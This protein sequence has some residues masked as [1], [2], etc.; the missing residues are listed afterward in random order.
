MVTMDRLA[1]TEYV[2]LADPAHVTATAFGFFYNH[3]EHRSRTDA[4]QLYDGRCSAAKVTQLL[5]LL[6]ELYAPTGLDYQKVSGHDQATYTALLPELSERG[7]SCYRCWMMT[8][9]QPPQR[10]ANPA[11][12]VQVVEPATLPLLDALY[13]T[14]DGLDQGYLFE[15]SQAARVGGERLLALKDGQAIGCTGWFV[16]NGVA[17]FRHV[18]T[19]APARK[20][21][22][23]TTLIRYI[24]EHPT[25][26]AQDALVIF[27]GE[28]GPIPLYEQLGFVKQGFTWE[29]LYRKQPR[30]NA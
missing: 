8:F 7:W 3:P 15:R 5:A 16:V 21:G 27:C 18:L 26:K 28:E 14:D 12:E 2:H 24:Q 6:D 1:A 17:R 22:A 4:H 10:M 11:I 23:A 25:V 19:S 30:D 29:F 9:D 20:Q 13:T